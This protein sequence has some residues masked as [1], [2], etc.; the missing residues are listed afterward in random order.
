MKKVFKGKSTREEKMY[1][2]TTSNANLWLS[3]CYSPLFDSEGNVTRAMAVVEDI[4]DRKK[5]EQEVKQ[6]N[7]DL[8]LKVIERT[9]QLEATNK[10]LESEVASRIKADEAL[11]NNLAHLSKM[12]K[13][14]SIIRTVIQ[15]V[16]QSIN[17]DDVFE[18]AVEALRQ[19]VE[20]VENVSIYLVD[21][22]KAVLKSYR[23][24]SPDIMESKLKTIPYPKGFTW[25]VIK[26]GKHR[27]CPDTEKDK[28]IGPAGRKLGTKSYLCM[29]IKNEGKT[30][31]VIST[32]SFKKNA[33][34]KEEIKLLGNVADQIETAINNAQQAEVLRKSQQALEKNLDE[35]TKK[36]NYEEII[37]TITRSVHKSIDL[38]EVMENAVDSMNK[39]VSGADCV[40]IYM[41]EDKTAV[42]KAHTGLS[43][44]YIKSAGRIHKPKGLT[45]KTL[46]DGKSRYVADVEKDTVIGPAGRKLGTKSYLS[47]PISFDNKAIGVLIIMSLQKNAFGN[48]ELKLL[49]IIVKQIEIAINNAKQA[50]RLKENLL[51]LTKKTKYETIIRTVT[52]IVHQS[53]D[54]DEV[55]ENAVEAIY[56]NIDLSGYISLYIVEGEEAVLR[57][58]RGY[59][60][61]Y[62]KRVKRIPYPKGVTWKIINEGKTRYVADA[63]QDEVIGPAGKELGTKCYLSMPIHFKG[64][65]IGCINI[66]SLKQDA[67]DEDDI[68]QLNVVTQQIDVAITNA[69]QA[70]ALERRTKIIDQVRD[71]VIT[72]DLGGLVTSWNKGAER[73]YGWTSEEA[74]GQHIH[75]LIHPEDDLEYLKSITLDPVREKGEHQVEKLMKKKSGE[76]FWGHISLSQIKDNNGNLTGYH[77]YSMDITERKNT[78]EKIKSSLKEKEVLLKEI[79]HRVKNNLQVISSLFYFQAKQV[80]DQHTRDIFTQSQNRIKTMALIHEKFYQSH[81]LRKIEVGQYVESL[82]KDILNSLIPEGNKIQVDVNVSDVLFNVDT[83]S[84]CGLI[85]NELI[86]NSIKH[87]FPDGKYGKVS[88]YIGLVRKNKYKLIFRDNGV[89]FPENINFRD[90]DTLGLQLINTLVEQLDGTIELIVNNGTEFKIYFSELNYE[91]RM[92]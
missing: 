66:S 74:M 36:K 59:P 16:H 79:H 2:A 82:A 77:S 55:F 21:Q 23:G 54:L 67:F 89:G 7:Q 35:L 64:N 31:G 46:V 18:N 91:H 12:N 71:S 3:A 30:I 42:L 61:W 69:Q 43:E 86:S 56:S 44:E 88:I 26:D 90:T 33:F 8:E 51:Q 4:S 20:N 38:N 37:S 84:P 48:E 17:L 45:W 40:I 5:A 63:E 78:E 11:R 32:N 65:T 28:Y 19:N 24:Y 25:K 58:Y 1:K 47:M 73:L 10:E 87:A 81:D 34:D 49:D 62:I 68:K 80:K 57:A 6:L 72:S 52:Q 27:Y 76:E 39:N 75:L 53:I 14:E 13:Y 9:S 15:N 29:P 92:E 50:E 85:I 41:V 83:A 22:N 70:E 60:D